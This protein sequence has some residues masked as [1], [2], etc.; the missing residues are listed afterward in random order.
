MITKII[1]GITKIIFILVTLYISSPVLLNGFGGF[2]SREFT[3]GVIALIACLLGY[4]ALVWNYKSSLWLTL[5]TISVGVAVLSLVDPTYAEFDPIDIPEGSVLMITGGSKGIGLAGIQLLKE[6]NLFDKIVVASRSPP[7]L[8]G[9][10]W[11]KA[12]LGSLKGVDGFVEE[13]NSKYDRLD[14]LILNAGINTLQPGAV[15][16]TEEGYSKIVIINHLSQAKLVMALGDKLKESKL[17]RVIFT[18][19]LANMNATIEEVV[20]PLTE[21][22]PNGYSSTKAQQIAF[23]K[24]LAKRGHFSTSFHPGAIATE[25]FN[26]EGDVSPEDLSYS[27]YQTT[28]FAPVIEQI[29]AVLQQVVNISWEPMI[30]GGQR[31]LWSSLDKTVPNGA[32]VANYGQFDRFMLDI[33]D[34]VIEHVYEATIKAIQ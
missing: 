19:S 21:P 14:M 15:D 9:V 26:L 22:V 27:L 34:T 6:M 2:I 13:F 1:S 23:S 24:A 5:I 12:D 31:L 28:L 30:N 18:S 8:D 29:Y 17:N 20:A 16:L 10:E 3:Y 32:F 4:V 11:I 7:A 33:N 25:I